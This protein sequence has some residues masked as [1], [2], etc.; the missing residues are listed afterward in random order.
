MKTSFF[1]GNLTRLNKQK[2]RSQSSTVH[3]LKNQAKCIVEQAVIFT[4]EQE[5]AIANITEVRAAANYFGFDPD[6]ICNDFPAFQFMRTTA[7]NELKIYCNQFSTKPATTINATV[8][9]QSHSSNRYR[10]HVK[11][12]P[13]RQIA[14]M[15]SLWQS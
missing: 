14:A 15:A 11:L 9:G 13:K 1:G 6:S 5:S 10:T 7:S 3:C 8:V 2:R 12:W 4:D